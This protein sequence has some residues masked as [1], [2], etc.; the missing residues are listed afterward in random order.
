MS[1]IVVLNHL[2]AKCVLIADVPTITKEKKKKRKK[3]PLF[4]I[5]QLKNN[6]MKKNVFD[7][8]KEMISEAVGLTLER[9][10]TL[11]EKCDKKFNDDDSKQTTSQ[12][13]EIIV[14]EC[15][16]IE[17]AA[18]VTYSIDKRQGQQMGLK[19]LLGMFSHGE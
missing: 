2:R 4:I 18:F 13:L 1:V 17:E 12:L 15:D 6:K 11:A 8:E 16:T 5:N 19:S 14:D 3:I 7:H 9:S 10:I